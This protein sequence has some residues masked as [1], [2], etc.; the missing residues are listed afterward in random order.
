MVL[1]SL[2]LA[3]LS[4]HADMLSLTTDVRSLTDTVMQEVS[5]RNY[6]GGLDLLKQYS[7]LSSAEIDT[8]ETTLRAQSPKIE[9]NYG[10]IIGVEF[11]EQKQIGDSLLRVTY[12]LKMQRF[13]LQWTFT[14][15]KGEAGWSLIVLDYNDKL[16]SLFSR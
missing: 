7:I 3:T 13:A 4:A 16:Q 1:S 10:K 14:F 9:S 15:Y 5:G 2:L 11:L 6:N 12:L 8:I